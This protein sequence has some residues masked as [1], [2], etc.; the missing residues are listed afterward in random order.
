MVNALEQPADPLPEE[1]LRATARSVTHS[2]TTVRPLP[3]DRTLLSI[4]LLTFLA[5]SVLGASSFGFYGFEKLSLSQLLTYYSV[6]TGLGFLFSIVTVQGIIPGSRKLIQLPWLVALM[7]VLLVALPF[8][9]FHDISLVRFVPLGI[10]CL[11]LGCL[12]ALA[13]GVLAIV[14]LKRGFVTSPLQVALS[15]G[16]FAGLAGFS[17]LALHCPIL[18]AAHVVVWHGGAV[19]AGGVAG[20]IVGFVRE[21]IS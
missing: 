5:F 2:L 16:L 6:L 20:M 8:A 9:L 14:F 7:L 12:S 21:R 18:N 11:R 10:P 19:L 1:R 15:A 17:V 13:F 3:P 4:G